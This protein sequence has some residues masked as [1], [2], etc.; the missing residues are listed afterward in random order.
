MSVLTL[1]LC[2]TA[3]L[4]WLPV[5]AFKCTLNHCT[6]SSSSLTFNII[7]K[8]REWNITI[9]TSCLLDLVNDMQPPSDITRAKHADHYSLASICRKRTHFNIVAT[10][11]PESTSESVTYTGADWRIW[12]GVSGCGRNAFRVSL[13]VS[14]LIRRNG[15]VHRVAKNCDCFA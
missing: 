12:I 9:A 4:S 3:R 13:H 7:T 15:D 8:L 1:A 14:D 6:S 11:Q 10:H 5:I 2:A